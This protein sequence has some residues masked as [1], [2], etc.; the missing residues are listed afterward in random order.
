MPTAAQDRVRTG[1]AAW[2]ELQEALRELAELNKDEILRAARA[3]KDSGEP[4]RP[5]R[6]NPRTGA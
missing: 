3:A 5:A 2:K 1:V 6:R 4:K